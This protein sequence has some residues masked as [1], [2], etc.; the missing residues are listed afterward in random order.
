MFGIKRK[1]QF[2]IMK[3]NWINNH[4]G[5]FPMNYFDI[6][7]V[8]IGKNSYGELNVISFNNRLHLYIGNYVSIAQKV[9]FLLDVEHNLTTV[10]TFPFNNKIINGTNEAYGKGDIVIDDDVW[11]GYGATILSGVHVG[12]G[13]VIASGAVVTKDVPPY[14]IVGGV[15]AKI[16]KYRF[17]VDVI[18]YLLTLSFEKLD[19]FCIKSH[20]DDLYVDLSNLSISD[21]EKKYQWFPKKEDKR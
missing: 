9:T 10:S 4:P 2:M 17:S 7:S 5:S 6:N 20:A 13:A 3:R 16:L 11:I 21:V 18:N 19:D 14:A 12:Q 15:P 1:I 8:S